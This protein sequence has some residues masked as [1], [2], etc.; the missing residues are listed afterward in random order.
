METAAAWNDFTT[1]L[2]LLIGKRPISLRRDLCITRLACGSIAF[3]AFY[4]V[5]EPAVGI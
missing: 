3:P 4:D 5:S 1:R 2:K